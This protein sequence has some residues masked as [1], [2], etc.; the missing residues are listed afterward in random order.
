[1][2]LFH[3]ALASLAHERWFTPGRFAPYLEHPFAPE[4]LIPVAIALGTTAV[5]LRSSLA[6]SSRK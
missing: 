2:A 4:T 3:L 1:M 5:A 6:C